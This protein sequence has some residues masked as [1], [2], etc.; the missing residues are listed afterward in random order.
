[1]MI[2][3][4]NLLNYI[5]S[6]SFNEHNLLNV[7][8]INSLIRYIVRILANIL[9]PFM[10][11][12]KKEFGLNTKKRNKKLIV[13]LTSF[14]NRIPKIWMVIETLL[15]QTVKAD[16]IILYLSELQFPQRE[17]NLPN[18]LLKMRERGLDIEFVN[19]DIRS[20]KKYYYVMQSYPN[21]YI[22]TVD[23]DIFY[24]TTM[25]QT[26]LDYHRQY[27]QDVICRYAKKIKWTKDSNIATSISWK[28]IYNTQI[29]TNDSFLGTGGGT[30]FPNPTKIFY[31]DI[32]NLQLALKLCPLEDDLW[33]NTMLR[34]QGT[35]ITVVKDYKG[36]LPILNSQDMML[37][38]NNGGEN[39]LTDKQLNDT[40]EYYKERNLYPY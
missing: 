7:L 11:S 8:K 6:F 24:P 16:K 17:Q 40:I 1:M 2:D 39:G 20:H 26:L 22:I 5:Y 29:N 18:S 21:D 37:Y 14:P 33:I 15:E 38:T 27:P 3:M 35:K 31:K 28:H 30:L 10:L 19:N 12:N 9:L 4:I 36:I 23:D 34:L 32:L 13:S 25:I